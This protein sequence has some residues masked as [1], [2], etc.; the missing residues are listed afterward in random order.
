MGS[1]SQPMLV[2]KFNRALLKKRKLKDIKD[3]MLENSGKTELEFKKVSLEEMA[4]IKAGIREQHRKDIRR[5]I[6]IYIIS[7]AI[8]IGICYA[9]YQWVT[10]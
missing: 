10:S 4:Q 2:I 6:I 3:L 1:A 5:E 7:A 9:L 8:T